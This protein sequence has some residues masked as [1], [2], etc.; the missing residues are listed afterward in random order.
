MKQERF[1]QIDALFEEVLDAPTLEREEILAE[2]CADDLELKNK[3]LSLIKALKTSE[4]F[5]ENTEFT[6]VSKFIENTEDKYI[7]KKIG[8]YELKKLIGRGGMSAVY[9]ATRIDDY[10]REVAVKI[11]PPFE[12]RKN[13]AENFRRERQILANLSHPFIAQIVDGGTTDDNKPYIVMEYVEGL[14]LD[15]FCNA[16]NFTVKQKIKLL[17]E[18]CEAVTFAHRNLIVHR[19]LKPHNILV[20]KSGVPKLLDFGVAK[21]LVEKTF[22]VSENKTFDGNALTLEYASPE[23]VLGENITV[24]SDV[25]SLGVI[26]YELLTGNRPHE[27]KNKSLGEIVKIIKAEEPAPPSRIQN[28]SFKIQ[29]FDSELDSIVLKSL[30]KSP[31]ERYQTAEEFSKD[32]DN[33]LNNQPVS[34]KKSTSVYR[35]KKYIQRHRIEAFVGL[36]IAF[37]LTGWLATFAWSYS[38]ELLQAR[39]SR[40]TAYSAE[41]ILAA[42]EYEKSN[43]NRLREIVEKYKTPQ[44]GEEDLRGFEWYFLSGLL[45]PTAKI[46]TFPHSDEIWSAKFSPDGK[47]IATAGNDNLVRVFD[48]ETG[49]T[50]ISKEQK[51][52]WRIA[53]FPDG[54]SFAVAS[55]SSSEPL[56]KIYETA[57][58]KEV[59]TLKGFRK[60]VRAVAVSPDGKTIATGDHEGILKIWDAENGTE[61]RKLEFGSREK[62]IEIN[63]VRFSRNSKKLAVLGN[64]TL[65]LYD[66]EN[67]SEKT[68][69]Y[70]QLIDRNLFLSGWEM[71]FSPLDKSIAI[72]TFEGDVIFFDTTDLKIINVI[73]LHNANVKSLTFS[74]DGKVL[75]TA[76][77]D[78]TVKFVN[79]P[80]GEILNELHGHFAGVH[81]LAFSADGKT[82]LTAGADFNLN[83]WDAEQVKQENA[84]LTLASKFVFSKDGKYGYG[85]NNIAGEL[86]AFDLGSKH[87]LWKIKD[88]ISVLS[89]DQS[90]VSNIITTGEKDG[91]VSVFNAKDGTK[92]KRFQ[93]HNKTIYSIKISSDG[94][95]IFTAHEDGILQA[96]NYQTLEKKFTIKADT[97]ILKFVD[98]SPD[99]KF[100]VTGG[101]SKNIK[102]FDA[103]SG[104]ELQSFSDHKKPL[105]TSIFSSD[106]KLF[107]TMGADEF[108]NFRRVS[109]WN[110][111]RKLSGT[112]AGVFAAAFSPDG[113]R[114]A[115]ASDVGRI[116]LWN[117]ESGEQVLAFTANNKQIVNLKFS[118]DG[119]V[120]MSVDINGKLQFWH[121]K[122]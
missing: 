110:L 60:R 97:E 120:L 75:A 25:Y 72:G 42:N 88:S 4:D 87:T 81:D 46:K 117:V 86:S 84:L 76:S 102:V 112:S 56:V 36:L 49:K 78:R 5:I 45:D 41:M 37:L 40:R 1:Q 27:L 47:F 122:K 79:Y 17:Q 63:A 65:T 94:K 92:L 2:K 98:E 114:I 7:G 93:P 57:T 66:T 116:R 101:N 58:L 11:I 91:F 106:G 107:V 85:W 96:T 29:E 118:E 16:N 34:A 89:I 35:F 67:W 108:L 113:K 70:T 51:G 31:S 15:E 55:S 59:F 38:K 14:P 53:F 103:K 8:T 71:E 64:E 68:A 95:T 61:I 6:P 73:K 12:N 109:D 52:A 50:L 22:Q 20:N 21:L 74:P 30:A 43:L 82:L 105:Y 28:S 32:L 19:D 111:H 26:L 9:L 77:W 33:F 48:L 104:T 62:Q 24:A 44:N 3:I 99:R 115:T 39:E 18:V 23:Q 83:L 80:T 69:D 13:S 10:E 121:S 54:K 90:L 119:Q 100:L